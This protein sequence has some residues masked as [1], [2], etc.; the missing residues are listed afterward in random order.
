LCLGAGGKD[1]HVCER[2]CVSARGL[3]GSSYPERPLHL[4]AERCEGHSNLCTETGLNPTASALGQGSPPATS[5]PGLGS[6]LARSQPGM[7]PHPHTQAS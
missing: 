7:C 2:K 6:P 4:A 3:M 1:A 5:A